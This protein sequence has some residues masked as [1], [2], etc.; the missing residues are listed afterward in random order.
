[1]FNLVDSF[2][3]YIVWN[4]LISMIFFLPNFFCNFPES[5]VI[6]NQNY[7]IDSQFFLFFFHIFLRIWLSFLDISST[8]YFSSPFLL[9]YLYWQLYPQYPGTLLYAIP[10]SYLSIFILSVTILSRVFLLG[11]VKISQVPCIISLFPNSHFVP[12]VYF[13]FFLLESVFKY[14]MIICC[15]LIFKSEELKSWFRILCTWAGLVNWLAWFYSTRWIL[16]D[17]QYLLSGGFFLLRLFC[18]LQ[19]SNL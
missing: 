12:C 18:F 7:W 11:F 10:Y 17:P 3:I 5:L 4:F 9:N 13:G 15:S 6:T 19:R 8:S 2:Y 16:E 1:M 14:L